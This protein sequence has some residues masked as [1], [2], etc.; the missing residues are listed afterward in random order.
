ME[1]LDTKNQLA[2]RQTDGVSSRLNWRRRGMQ[3]LILVVLDDF[4]QFHAE[5]GVFAE[6]GRDLEQAKRLVPA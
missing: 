3:D 6:T 5:P 1:Y 2:C 4:I